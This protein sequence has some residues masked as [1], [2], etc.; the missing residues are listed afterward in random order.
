MRASRFTEDQILGILR[1]AE[2]GRHTVGELCHLHGISEGTFYRWKN[3]HTKPEGA[4]ARK[5][6]DLQHENERLKRCLANQMLENEA[7]KELLAKKW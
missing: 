7:I 3:R 2:T 6:R 5:M 4:E 1:E